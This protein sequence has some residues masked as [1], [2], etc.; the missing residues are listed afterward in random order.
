M[1]TDAGFIDLRATLDTQYKGFP[2]KRCPACGERGAVE[3]IGDNRLYIHT[4]RVVLQR[5]AAVI[6]IGESCLVPAVQP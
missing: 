6:E 4:A 3:A 2:I 5:G 1:T